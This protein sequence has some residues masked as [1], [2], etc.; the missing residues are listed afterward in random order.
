M[1]TNEVGLNV[2]TT[3]DNLKSFVPKAAV[4][5]AANNNLHKFSNTEKVTSAAAGKYKIAYPNDRSKSIGPFDKK[6]KYKLVYY[7]RF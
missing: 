6:D 7:F 5:N 1:L 2:N 3:V 4:Q